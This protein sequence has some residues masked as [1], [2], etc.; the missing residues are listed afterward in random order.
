MLKVF[1][2]T[3]ALKGFMELFAAAQ[4][5]MAVSWVFANRRQRSSCWN[6]L[7]YGSNTHLRIWSVPCHVLHSF[8]TLCSSAWMGRRKKLSTIVTVIFSVGVKVSQRGNW[9]SN[10]YLHLSQLLASAVRCDSKAIL[11]VELRRCKTSLLKLD[12][13]AD[14]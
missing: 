14:T 8:W 7:P 10:T 12:Q 13:E 3:V 11:V 2:L 5:G 6:A 4:A 1:F 9:D